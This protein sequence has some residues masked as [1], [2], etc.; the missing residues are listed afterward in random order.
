M[1][2]SHWTTRE[3]KARLVYC[4]AA[5]RILANNPPPSG[6]AS[7]FDIDPSK[8]KRLGAAMIIG[9]RRN[10]IACK[11]MGINW[12]GT[13]AQT[14]AKVA[15]FRRI[16][17]GQEPMTTVLRGFPGGFVAEVVEITHAKEI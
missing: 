6:I 13:D 14:L 17:A 2:T 7:V 11:E 1:Q 4:A 15:R 5:E 8:F 9:M 12:R 10:R 16:A 3:E